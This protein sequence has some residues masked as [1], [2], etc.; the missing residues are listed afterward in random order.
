M[1]Y[2][3]K[4]VDAE[5]ILCLAPIT[6]RQIAV[7]DSELSDCSG[8]FLFEQMGIT[9]CKSVRIIAQVHSHDAAL[10]LGEMMGL[11]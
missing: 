2:L 4:L 9:D 1:L 10:E 7:S 3:S 5:R 11:S 8:Y 6:K